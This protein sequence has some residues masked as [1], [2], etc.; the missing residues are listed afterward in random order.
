[1][2]EQFLHPLEI[3][4]FLVFFHGIKFPRRVRSDILFHAESGGGVFQIFENRLPRSVL[5]AVQTVLK[6]KVLSPHC[7]TSVA[8]VF[9]QA[10]APRFPGLFFP[11]REALPLYLFRLQIQ[12]IV[13]SQPGYKRYLTSKPIFR[14]KCPEYCLKAFL[15]KPFSPHIFTPS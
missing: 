4:A 14:S 11:D 7:D 12:Y 10:H 6:N 15:R 3:A 1:M 9:R 13:Y 8:K 5:P 2:I